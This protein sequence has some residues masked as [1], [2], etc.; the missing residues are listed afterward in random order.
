MQ[1]MH[2]YLDHEHKDIS[3]RTEERRI[4]QQ[5]QDKNVLMSKTS[6]SGNLTEF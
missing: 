1:R 5:K 4:I 2:K 6:A 3:K